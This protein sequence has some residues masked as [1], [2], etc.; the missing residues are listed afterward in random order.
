[1][2]KLRREILLN[3]LKLFDI[4]LMLGSFFLTT[5][6]IVRESGTMTLTEFLSM[7][8]KVGNLVLFLVLLALWHL[9]FSLSGLYESRRMS[10][11]RA[12]AKDTFTA[13]TIGV[14]LVAVAALVFHIRMIS[15]TFLLVF[16]AITSTAAV[17]TRLLLRSVLECSRLRGRNLRNMLIVG[18][19]SRALAFARNIEAKPERGFQIIGFVDD[20]WAG[21]EELKKSGRCVVCDFANV[22]VFLRN[23]VVDE[24][25]MALPLRSLH[26]QAAR[27]AALCEEQGITFRLLSN[28]FDLK[29][30]RAHSEEFDDTVFMTNYASVADGLPVFVKR[31]FDILLSSILLVGLAPL[32]IAVAALIRLRSPGPILFTQCRLGLNKRKFKIYKFRTM[33]TDAEQKMS[34]LE[35]LNEVSGPVFKIKSDPRVTPVGKFLRKSSIDELP[36]L[37][38]VLKGD[39][40]LVGP[41]PLP[42]RDYE[43]FNQDWQRRR[44][45]VRPGLTCLWQIN[46][47]SSVSFE[48]WMQLDMQYIDKW[49]LRLDLEILLR[50]I[51]AVLRGSGAA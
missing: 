3:T 14:L 8:I 39:M 12:D 40:S 11:R 43:G 2:T 51:P 21:L 35:H 44:F 19:N 42:V 41:R 38:N 13:A 45:I 23:N 34:E 25:V 37:F 27:I 4:V 28:I 50:T 5:L 16:W 1:M 31:G 32:L 26:N 20:E 30:A 46:G 36:Q 47:R 15:P 7:R 49:S 29:V 24:V 10:G 17:T 9:V 33:T 22:A 48:K 18:T 6:L